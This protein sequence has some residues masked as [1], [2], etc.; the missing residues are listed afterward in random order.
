MGASTGAD[1]SRELEFRNYDGPGGSGRPIRKLLV[2][3]LLLLLFPF[4][5]KKM[6]SGTH[7]VP[8]R[9]LF[10]GHQGVKKKMVG[11]LLQ[12]LLLKFG[13]AGC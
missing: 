8:R 4:P 9:L 3:L 12:V 2:G 11:V 7:D 10:S 5:Q 6:P 13:R 1:L